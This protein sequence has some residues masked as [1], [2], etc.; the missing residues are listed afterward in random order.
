LCALSR[1][2]KRRAVSYV[3]VLEGGFTEERSK[4]EIVFR[5]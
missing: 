4:I 2:S 5:E 1:E 3:Y